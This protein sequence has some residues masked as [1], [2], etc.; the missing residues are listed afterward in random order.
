MLAR[1][2][3]SAALAVVGLG[4]LSG[5][6][7]AADASGDPAAGETA[8]KAQCMGCHV[9][10]LGQKGVLAPSLRGVVGRKAASTGFSYSVALKASGLTWTKANLDTFL[11]AP[12]K[13]VPGTRMFIA[14]TDPQQR[15][16]VV[17]YLATL[18]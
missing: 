4:V 3:Y 13:M 18:K 8:F 15:A 14:I 10:G 16:N 7:A 11:A 17:A 2:V 9:V 6:V 12:T 5:G 1:I